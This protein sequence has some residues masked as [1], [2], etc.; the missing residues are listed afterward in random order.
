MEN[1]DFKDAE[2]FITRQY[3]KWFDFVDKSSIPNSLMDNF[4]LKKFGH[5]ALNKDIYFLIKKD[6]P[7]NE[8]ESF[9]KFVDS[10][11][12]EQLKT[13]SFTQTEALVN[14]YNTVIETMIECAEETRQSD[15]EVVNDISGNP[16]ECLYS[17]L[18]DNVELR[19]GSESKRIVKEL[20]NAVLCGKRQI[21]SSKFDSTQI[22]DILSKIKDDSLMTPDALLASAI[23]IYQQTQYNVMSDKVINQLNTIYE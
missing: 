16:Q 11:D 12:R 15:I 2:E 4:N 3:E 5:N 6:I 8:I 18:I 21:A 1:K 13:F 17:E 10:N 19:Y 14:K 7:Y 22:K 20:Q 23:N 9:I